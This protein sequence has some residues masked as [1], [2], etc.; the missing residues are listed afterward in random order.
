MLAERGTPEQKQVCDDLWSGKLDTQEKMRRYYE[1]MGPMY[2]KKFDPVA[3]KAG[4]ERGINSPEPMLKAFAPGG[5]LQTYDLRPELKNIT[6]PTLI[7]AGRHDFTAFAASDDRDGKR[8]SK[9]RTIFSSQSWSEADLLVY[10]VR[11]SGFLKHMVRNIAGV[12]LQVG[13]G[14]VSQDKLR[15][16]LQPNCGIPAGPTA[17]ARGLC[18]MSVEYPVSETPS[19][20]SK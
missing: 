16:R 9:V 6:A 3:A 20:T 12:L 11:G 7:L 15:A 5:F 1:L 4:R 14:N 10:R 8:G 18:L 2:A 13:Q 17:P 19:G